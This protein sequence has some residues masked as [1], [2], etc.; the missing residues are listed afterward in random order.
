MSLSNF[1]SVEVAVQRVEEWQQ[2]GAVGCESSRT[3][4]PLLGEQ[5]HRKGRRDAQ[6]KRVVILSG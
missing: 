6:E 3:V 2:I 5:M 1:G 4:P